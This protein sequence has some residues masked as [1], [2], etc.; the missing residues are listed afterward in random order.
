MQVVIVYDPPKRD[1][2]KNKI[3][4][5]YLKQNHF[6]DVAILADELGLSIQFIQMRMRRLGLRKC[7][8]KTD[9]II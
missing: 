2:Y 3:R 8:N 9:R 1:I 4:D 6:I 5:E 7:R